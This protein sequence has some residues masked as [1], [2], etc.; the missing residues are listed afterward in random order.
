MPK[1]C[2][3]CL[4]PD[5]KRFLRT[6]FGSPEL[7]RRLAQLEDCG[8]TVGVELCDGR[9]VKKRSEY[10]QWISTCMKSKNLTGFSPEAMKQCA[11]E[12]RGRSRD[13][14]NSNT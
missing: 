2:T 10:Q 13:A 14:L 5:V 9:K 7:D 11:V 6:N 1:T 4:P 12:W 3:P 8:S